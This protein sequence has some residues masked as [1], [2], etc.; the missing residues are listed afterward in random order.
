MSIKP[1]LQE[2]TV[3]APSTAADRVKEIAAMMKGE[4]NDKTVVTPMSEV[5]EGNEAVDETTNDELEEARAIEEA[6]ETPVEKAERLYANKYKTPEAME[7][8]YLESQKNM[9]KKSSEADNYKKL[10]AKL[11][12]EIETIKAQ[13]SELSKPVETPESEEEPEG[14]LYDDPKA[15]IENIINKTLKSV[16][17]NIENK[18]KPIEE[19]VT[20]MTNARKV[21]DLAARFARE[22]PDWKQ[23]EEGMSEAFQRYP[24]LEKSDNGLEIAYNMAA[25]PSSE[26]TPEMRNKI[27]QERLAEIKKKNS[28]PPISRSESSSAIAIPDIKPSTIKNTRP[29]MM[30]A[31]KRAFKK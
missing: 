16:L 25:K 12:A 2:D 21:A 1:E 23:R 6:L 22:H 13:V 4:P 8:G 18:I 19:T 7:T 30:S 14:D 20:N 10:N 3:K 17:P 24:E 28:A 5:E 31:L 29:Q 26:I 9:L 27:L 15:Y 11:M